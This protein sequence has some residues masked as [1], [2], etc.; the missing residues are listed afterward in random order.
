MMGT[1]DM[2]AL[3]AQAEAECARHQESMAHAVD[4][5]AAMMEEASHQ[6]T[7][8]TMMGQMMEMHDQM[9]G[10]GMMGGGM[11]GGGMMGAA[12]YACSTTSAP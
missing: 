7:M 2:G 9:M 3:V 6:A 1:G 8:T 11:M 10:G 5:N 12:N 4:M